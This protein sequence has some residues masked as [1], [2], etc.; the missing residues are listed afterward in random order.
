MEYTFEP[1]RY[2]EQYYS[3]TC[4]FSILTVHR[5]YYAPLLCQS[6]VPQKDFFLRVLVPLNIICTVEILEY[7]F[8]NIR[9]FLLNEKNILVQFFCLSIHIQKCFK[10]Y[11]M[12]VLKFFFFLF[13]SD[14]KTS[15]C[16]GTLFSFS[17]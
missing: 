15:L 9:C 8:L 17:S 14:Q 6:S 7:V 4:A 2:S 5:V 16:T 3:G 11:L 12:A 13:K 10:I 1:Y